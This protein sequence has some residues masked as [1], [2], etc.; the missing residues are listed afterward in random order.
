[1]KT[2]KEHLGEWPKF[3]PNKQT[4]N[5]LGSTVVYTRNEHVG[6]KEIE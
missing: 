3:N 5:R 2:I 6:E 4:R 1:M